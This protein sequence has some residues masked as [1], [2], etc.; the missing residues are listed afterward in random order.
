MNI[1]NDNFTLTDRRGSAFVKSDQINPDYAKNQ[2]SYAFVED[3]QD[4]YYWSLP[5]QFVGN[6]ILSYGGELKFN[7]AND[8][9][10]SG[11]VPDQDVILSGNGITLFWS[12]QVHTNEVFSLNGFL[13]IS[14]IKCIN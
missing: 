2:L 8:D 5:K 13:L 3:Y 10:G 4:T 9:Y 11:Y 14:C 6:H 7:V 1:F 12:R